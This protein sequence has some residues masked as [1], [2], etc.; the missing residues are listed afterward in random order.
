MSSEHT[1]PARAD[2]PGGSGDVQPPV[3]RL[4]S[5]KTAFVLFRAALWAWVGAALVF[6]LV[7]L[8]WI[9]AGGS[10][11]PTS[12]SQPTSSG[13]GT[14]WWMTYVVHPHVPRL[15]DLLVDVPGRA[16]THFLLGGML[17]MARR[18]LRGEPIRALDVFSVRGVWRPLAV[19][20]ILLAAVM[21][22]PSHFG[23]ITQVLVGAPLLFVLP[24]VVAGG[25]SP[26][27][28]IARSASALWRRLVPA[29][30]LMLGFEA[31]IFL[32]AIVTPF[33][34]LPLVVLW[35]AVTYDEWARGEAPSVSRRKVAN[36]G[37]VL[38][39]GCAVNIVGWLGLVAALSS[40]YY[41]AARVPAGQIPP[42]RVAA[43]SGNG[44]TAAAACVF[45][46]TE[47]SLVIWDVHS[48]K[49]LGPVALDAPAKAL[50]MS[51]DGR[52]IAV[53]SEHTAVLFNEQ[54]K[55]IK[56]LSTKDEELRSLCF[57]DDGKRLAAASGDG[58]LHIWDLHTGQSRQIGR[59]TGEDSRVV[60]VSPDGKAFAVGEDAGLRH[61]FERTRIN[62][63]DA[64]TGKAVASINCGASPATAVAFSPDGRSLATGHADGS[65]S[66]H[67][68]ES[69]KQTILP[70]R[71]IGLTRSV[72]LSYGGEAVAA[73]SSSSLVL[74]QTASR[75]VRLLR[76]P[77]P[78][79][80]FG[81]VSLSADGA[82]ALVAV[83][84]SQRPLDNWLGRATGSAHLYD[85]RTGRMM[86]VLD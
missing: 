1:A 9:L 3:I 43:L 42:I 81:S 63:Q 44:Q 70:Q 67:A 21:A 53:P 19:T 4:S 48:G 86:R 36:A 32:S 24:I 64:A 49:R 66:T 2:T 85:V 45:R 8:A 14:A 62:V 82:L 59:K 73:A 10:L 51:A 20:S 46:G 75:R 60:E 76:T 57:T 26:L 50:A 35:L 39:G 16:L 71:L 68:L 30:G 40:L 31:L 17:L 47:Y 79:Q 18:Q 84:N 61:W 7:W 34:T 58:R 80:S 29:A 69:S 25:A 78:F 22:L 74:W 41:Y 77:S 12:W 27:T 52:M 56:R 11:M 13:V 54:A 23:L 28:A 65:V 6:V 83:S 37:A 5:L 72:A 55:V 38:A 33:V 15:L